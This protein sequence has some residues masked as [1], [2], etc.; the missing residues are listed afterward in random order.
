MQCKPVLILWTT[1]AILAILQSTIATRIFNARPAV[2]PAPAQSSPAA[3]SPAASSFATPSAQPPVDLSTLDPQDPRVL[4]LDPIH[5]QVTTINGEVVNDLRGQRGLV[6]QRIAL[7]GGSSKIPAAPNAL[8]PG[9]FARGARPAFASSFSSSPSSFTPR[10]PLP[11]QPLEEAQGG[12]MTPQRNGFQQQPNPMSKRQ[13]KKQARF[14]RLQ[15]QKSRAL[16]RSQR[17]QE[18][19]TRNQ[20]Q[21]QQWQQRQGQ[22]ETPGLEETTLGLG[23]NT[24]TDQGESASW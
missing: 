1:V 3:F 2:Q 10:R 16:T 24:P 18:N 21:H 5:Q 22:Q 14:D 15:E 23:E 13:Q 9:P 20:Q 17:Q 8:S 4:G 7:L 6:A 12:I 11:Q 19:F